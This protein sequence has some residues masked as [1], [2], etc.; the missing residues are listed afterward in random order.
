[1]FS[2]SLY[3][4]PLLDE[5]TGQNSCY[6]ASSVYPA[7]SKAAPALIFWNSRDRDAF[8]NDRVRFTTVMHR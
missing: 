8:G 7:R 5:M 6:H 1:M 4:C 2:R 3:T